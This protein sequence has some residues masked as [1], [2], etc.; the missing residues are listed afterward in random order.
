[1]QQNWTRWIVGGVVVVSIILSSMLF[2]LPE[3]RVAVVTRFGNPVRTHDRPGLHMKLP[4]PCERAYILDARKRVSETRLTETLTK[5]K[6]N[7]ILVTYSVWQVDTQGNGPVN[8]LQALGDIPGAEGKLDGVVTNAKNSVL[9]NYD[10]TDL[11]SLDEDE[12]KI[13]KIEQDILEEVRREVQ[14]REG[15][16]GYGIQVS[17]IG[18]KRLALPEENISYVFEQMRAERRQFAERFRAEGEKEASVIRAETDL[19]VARLRAEGKEKSAEIRGEAEAQAAQIYAAAHRMDPSF[20]RFTRS[21]ESLQKL[22]G[23]NTTVVLDTRTPPF[24][25]LKNPGIAESGGRR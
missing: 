23:A 5:D 16:A 25:V 12:Q 14:A 18:I 17:Q 15:M 10:F 22:L 8:F 13:D 7:L 1:M 9:G 2:S 19:Q 20:Y 11:V 24:D 21:L 6:K 3:N 4:V